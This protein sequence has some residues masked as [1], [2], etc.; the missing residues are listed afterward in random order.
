MRARDINTQHD[1]IVSNYKIEKMGDKFIHSFTPKTTETIYR[2]ETT[3][4]TPVAV[5]GLHY[6]V[7]YIPEDGYRRVDLSSL[8]RTSDLNPLLSLSVALELGQ[9]NLEVEKAKN[10]ARLTHDATDG[11]YWAKKQAWRIYGMCIG[12]DAFI[13]YLKEIK[14]PSIPCTMQ[15]EGFAPSPSTAYLDE[16]LVDAMEKLI[17]SAVKKGRYYQS[18]YYSKKFNIDGIAAISDKK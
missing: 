4:E 7:G 3:T 8:S 10:E 12:K 16:G 13:N 15:K 6:N 18:P 9:S 11:Y 1:L 2:L 5:E 17:G 14:H